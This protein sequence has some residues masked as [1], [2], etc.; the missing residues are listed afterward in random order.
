MSVGQLFL[1]W[2]LGLAVF[3]SFGIR[4]DGELRWL[5][6][7]LYI[8]VTVSFTAIFWTVV[9]FWWLWNYLS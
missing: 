6:G 3:F 7:I 8:Y 2:L 1:M 9:A 5:P 4:E